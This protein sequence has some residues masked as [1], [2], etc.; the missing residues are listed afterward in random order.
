MT[1]IEA[2]AT[3]PLTVTLTAPLHHGAGTAGNTAL[4]RTQDIVLPDGGSAQVP[5]VS[6]NSLRHALRS[7]LA[8]HLVRTLGIPD[9]SLS[10]AVADLLWSGGA[11]SRTGAQTDLALSRRVD[12]LAPFLGLLGYAAGADITGGTLF[13]QNLHLVCAENTWRLPPALAGSPHAAL[14]AHAYRDEEFGT[15]HD[16][17]GSPVD[18]YIQL[19]TLAAGATTQMIYDLEV[20]RPGSILSGGVT[21]AA[22]AT[23]AH[24]LVL[25]AALDL[26][27]PVVDGTRTIRLAAKNAVG[28]GTGTL[29]VDLTGVDPQG[30]GLEWWTQHSADNAEAILAL[31]E[32]V[33]R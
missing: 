23:G 4:L 27:A 15:R 12:E 13:V 25:A 16:I 28:Y 21:L 31:L 9:G 19:A 22:S 32:E 11:I 7:A 33:V 20:L 6:G 26:A 14:P 1:T 3:V 8:W 18:R 5:F 30:I 24:R 10:K 17:A 2:T 29:E